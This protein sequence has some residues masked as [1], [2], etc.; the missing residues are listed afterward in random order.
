MLIWKAFN[1]VMQTVGLSL[2]I[3][4]GHDSIVFGISLDFKTWIKS[5]LKL[6]KL[7]LQLISWAYDKPKKISENI[8]EQKIT[9]YYFFN[10]QT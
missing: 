1:L 7:C 5:V 3:R 2:F 6:F 10:T 8:F 4:V 9:K